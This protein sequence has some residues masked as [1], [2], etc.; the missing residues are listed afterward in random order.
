VDVRLYAQVNVQFEEEFRGIW[1]CEISM[2]N[3]SQPNRMRPCENEYDD[4]VNNI[5]AKF[6]YTGTEFRTIEYIGHLNPCRQ[7]SKTVSTAYINVPYITCRLKFFLFFTGPTAPLSPGLWFSFMIILQT[8]GLLGRVISSSKGLYLNTGQH[9]HRI[10]TYTHQTSM[11][12]VG[13]ESTIPASERAKTV[14]A[15]DRSDTVTG[16]ILSYLHIF[17][18]SFCMIFS[19]PP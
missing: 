14:H 5:L 9:K 1:A 3:L 4:I 11:L 8:V 7:S 6:K 19:S 18:V 13:F 16:K 15:L 12:C 17:Q 2:H 10:N